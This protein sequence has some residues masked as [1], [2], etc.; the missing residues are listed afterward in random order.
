MITGS[1]TEWYVRCKMLHMDGLWTSLPQKSKLNVLF[2]HS[3]AFLVVLS[4]LGRNSELL[5]ELGCYSFCGLVYS[6]MHLIDTVQLITSML[7]IYLALCIV[8]V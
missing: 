2:V 6:Y 3:C 5:H 7:K 8:S 1:C 4:S